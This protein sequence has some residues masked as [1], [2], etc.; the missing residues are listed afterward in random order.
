MNRFNFIINKIAF[1]AFSRKNSHFA[2]QFRP[3]IAIGGE[4]GNSG[5]EIVPGVRIWYVEHDN[6]ASHEGTTSG[7]TTADLE[8]FAFVRNPRTR[9]RS[10]ATRAALR[11]A[12]SEMTRGA[13]A[14][15]EW[16]FERSEF[17][18]P[19]LATGENKLKFSCSHTS[20]MSVIAVS[21]GGE[22]GIDIA[23][24]A[25]ASTSDWLADVMAPIEAQELVKLSPSARATAVA[26][27]WTLKEAY[28]KMLGIGIAEVSE[29]AF[30][31]SDDR[32][33]SGGSSG[34]RAKPSF[35]TWIVNTERHRHSV[36]LALSEIETSRAPV[37][38][39]SSEGSGVYSR[40]KFA[41]PAE[42][43]AARA[44]ASASVFRAASATAA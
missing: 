11:R 22:V 4:A 13:T 20:E 14:P 43:A 36:A 8:E 6:G 9:H 40:S 10:L 41:V 39:S 25:V 16:C 30:D 17:G 33:L 12:L 23:N 37:K 28:V 34:Y 42:R 32:L 27:L 15:G 7:L 3:E 44:A 18:Q 2:P 26:R 19:R 35:K 31:L 21:N 5:H 38:R 24:A 1:G 29:V